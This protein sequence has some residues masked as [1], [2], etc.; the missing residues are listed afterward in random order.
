MSALHAVLDLIEF[1]QLSGDAAIRR[2]TEKSDPD[3]TLARWAAQAVRAIQEAEPKIAATR[4]DTPVLEPV[5]RSWGRQRLNA[6]DVYEEAV[7]GRR[8]EADGIRE[9]RLLSTNSV[10]GAARE[11][12]DDAEI[13]FLVGVTAGARPI[14]GG[15][16]DHQRRFSLGRFTAPERIR[17]VEVGCADGSIDVRFDG[18]PAEAL[19]LYEDE[20]AGPLAELLADDSYRPGYDCAKCLLVE[21]CPGVPSVPGLLGVTGDTR[22]TWSVTSGREHQKCPDRYRFGEMFLP[23]ERAAE[24]SDGTRRGRAVHSWIAQRHD[25]RPIQACRASDVPASSETWSAGWAGRDGIEARLGVQMIGDHALVCPLAGLAGDTVRTEHLVVAFDPVANAVIVAKTDL[26]YRDDHGWV[27]REIKTARSPE[28]GDLL[29]KYPQLALAVLLSEAGV[30]A[31]E[32]A[33]LRVEL[34]EL[35]GSGPVLATLDVSSDAVLAAARRAVN[36]L[37]GPMF[38]M[39]T[40]GPNP[41]KACADCG[42][43][44]W[45]PAARKTAA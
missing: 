23:R 7:V 19:R 43:V 15:R 21:S 20:A 16:W 45:C 18:S 30:L 29:T 40:S 12:T 34:E 10:A 44:R 22:R 13:A 14:L 27:L 37:A 41:G 17:V 11:R 42:F 31:E 6:E 4:P 9:L 1:D 8:Y 35:T 28:T 36:R 24:D 3:P 32:G 39:E 25:R 2:W 33:P 26:L 5:S 38:T